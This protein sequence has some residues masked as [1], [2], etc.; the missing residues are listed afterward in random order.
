M[1]QTLDFIRAAAARKGIPLIINAGRR[2]AT[3]VSASSYAPQPAPAPTPAPRPVQQ[4]A[5]LS[6]FLGA[7]ATPGVLGASAF[8]RALQSGLS[9]AQIRS[10]AAAQGLSIGGGVAQPSGLNQFLGAN[11]AAGTL[12]IQAFNRAV[13]SGLTPQQIQSQAS[14][15]GLNFG[16]G[17]AQQFNQPAAVQNNKKFSKNQSLGKNL[18]A[19]GNTLS[20]S[21]LNKLAKISGKTKDQI[22]RK[23][24]Q[25]GLSI[26]SKVVNQYQSD[27][28]FFPD[29]I[30]GTVK[31]RE[32]TFDPFRN[33]PIL[34]A[35]NNA[36]KDKLKKGSKLFIGTQ[37]GA[38][39][40]LPRNQTISGG[41][42]PNNM[43][44]PMP[45]VDPQPTFTQQ[46]AV[47][48]QLGNQDLGVQD[49]L[50]QL[51]DNT[52]PLQ[53]ASLPA[54]EGFDTVSSDF[55]INDPLQFASLGQS[56]LTDA[57]LAA[58]RRQQSRRDYM[59]NMMM[60][61]GFMPGMSNLSIGGGVNVG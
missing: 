10:Q 55:D 49:F 44:Q 14:A 39:T 19:A 27:S 35:I 38:G 37:S 11:S 57:I 5:N 40:V 8:N 51:L 6:Q 1:S 23:A 12:G 24:V 3:K 29:V 36:R 25:K 31:G 54:L 20:Q 43:A 34:A 18:K 30:T 2:D 26:G 28:K 33:D 15:Q 13:Q 60:M 32:V 56:Y 61:A 50:D 16:P 46:P 21:E 48:Q 9:D 7:N 42:R 17:V 53:E 52:E 47:T 22:L 45:T 58:R 59:R 4:Q 41:G